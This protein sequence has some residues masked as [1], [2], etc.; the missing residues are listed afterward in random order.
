MLYH[1]LQLIAK[2][3]VRELVLGVVKLQ[4]PNKIVLNLK[5]INNEKNYWTS[6]CRRKE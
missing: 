2:A 5:E 4:V 3:D 1:C 6:N